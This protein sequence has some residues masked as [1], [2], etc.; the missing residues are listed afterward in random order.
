MCGEYDG[1]VPYEFRGSGGY[2]NPDQWHWLGYKGTGGP[3][4]FHEYTGI[5][6][7]IMQACP[8]YRKKTGRK[9]ISLKTVWNTGIGNFF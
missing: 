7:K 6:L 9:P 4:D 1:F 3:F 8:V 2:R 5:P